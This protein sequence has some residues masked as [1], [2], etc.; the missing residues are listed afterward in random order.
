MAATRA[1]CRPIAAIGHSTRRAS[2]TARATAQEAA[3][4]PDV[5]NGTRKRFTA[6]DA[7][8]LHGHRLGR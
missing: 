3:M 2:C 7:A 5:L 1:A 6:L 4:D 8:A